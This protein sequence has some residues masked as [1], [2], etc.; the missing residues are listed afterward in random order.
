MT[1]KLTTC[2]GG[3]ANKNWME[4]LYYVTWFIKTMSLNFR[5]LIVQINRLKARKASLAENKTNCVS[6]SIS[7]T[8]NNRKLNKTPLIRLRV[9]WTWPRRPK[10]ATEFSWQMLTFSSS[11]TSSNFRDNKESRENE[12][13]FISNI[14]VT[15]VTGSLKNWSVAKTFAT[16]RAQLL[17][18]L[19]LMS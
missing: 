3:C 7:C 5:D 12:Y 19:H 15:K 13:F 11:F 16:Y 6:R 2:T 17:C 1:I 10:H 9:N 4:S 14:P 18:E 8:E